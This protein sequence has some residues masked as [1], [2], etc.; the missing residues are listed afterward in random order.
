VIEIYIENTERSLTVRGSEHKRRGCRR[1]EVI[2]GRQLHLVRECMFLLC[3]NF[4]YKIETEKFV[5]I[6][7]TDCYVEHNYC[8]L[9]FL[10]PF[11]TFFPPFLFL[12]QKTMFIHVRIAYSLK[13]HYTIYKQTKNLL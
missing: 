5:L 4:F 12:E 11:S 6:I 7:W 1:S 3:C 13:S 10:C 8:M 2:G 9:L